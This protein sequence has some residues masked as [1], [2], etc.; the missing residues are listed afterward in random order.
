MYRAAKIYTF[1]LACRLFVSLEDP[2]HIKKLASQFN[3]FLKGIIQIPFNVPGTP[4][5]RAMKAANAIRKDLLAITRQRRI[6]L[7]H[8]TASPCQDLLSHL[9]VSSDENGRFFT[10][11]EIVNNIMTLLFAGHDTS[12]VS[13][14]LVMRTLAQLPHVYQKVYQGSFLC[15]SLCTFAT[16]IYSNI[17]FEFIQMFC[18]P[19]YSN[20]EVMFILIDALNRAYG[21]SSI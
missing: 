10:E 16:S 7:D 20:F 9:L 8:K 17:P 1:E 12:S 19:F 4:F 18:L 2:N 5:Y 13:I 14:T 11:M 3:I 15:L 21:Y 6:D